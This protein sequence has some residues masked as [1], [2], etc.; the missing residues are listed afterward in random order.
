VT[1]ILAGL[2]V[3]AGALGAVVR[4]AA[5]RI[6]ARERFPYAVLVVNAIGSLIAGLA[7]A[8]ATALGPEVT[9]IVVT[10]FCG[11]LTTF[12][13]FSVDTIRLAVRGRLLAAIG[14]VAANLALGVGAAALGCAL[15]LAL[16]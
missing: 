14:N 4:F 8:F 6:A 16:A 7:I 11:G 3:A 2:V 9:T 15:G 5:T 1:L 12:S 13:T 10:G